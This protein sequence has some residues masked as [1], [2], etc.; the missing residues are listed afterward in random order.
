[1]IVSNAT[2]RQL[3]R[4]SDTQLK[5][6]LGDFKARKEWEVIRGLDGRGAPMNDLASLQPISEK[7]G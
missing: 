4:L 1:L 5:C 2:P 6:A 7:A 3:L